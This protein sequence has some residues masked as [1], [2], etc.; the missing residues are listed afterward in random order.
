MED[1]ATHIQTCEDPVTIGYKRSAAV[2]F[3]SRLFH[4]LHLLF[5][6]PS[7]DLWSE[8]G[9]FQRYSGWCMW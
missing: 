5:D 8:C 2:A 3:A 6:S 9:R 1:C 7:Y 4:K